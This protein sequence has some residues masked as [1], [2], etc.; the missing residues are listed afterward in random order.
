MPPVFSFFLQGLPNASCVL[1][2]PGIHY[3]ETHCQDN[4]TMQ[5]RMALSLSSSESAF[6]MGKVLKTALPWLLSCRCDLL[7]LCNWNFIS[8]LL[9]AQ[10]PTA[11]LKTW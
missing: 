4:E 10:F 2:A 7:F 3:W 5:G 9:H 6:N 8:L 11:A 1:T